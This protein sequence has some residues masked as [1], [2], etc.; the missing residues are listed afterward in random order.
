MTKKGSRARQDG[1]EGRGE[2][3]EKRMRQGDTKRERDGGPLYTMSAWEGVDA[4]AEPIHQG[5]L[6]K[7]GQGSKNNTVQ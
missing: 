5:Q 3:G 1:G 2:G 6:R 7:D 4:G